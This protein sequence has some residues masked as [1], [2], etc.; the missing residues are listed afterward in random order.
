MKK[1]F[2]LFVVLMIALSLLCTSYAKTFSDV[3]NTKYA[4]AV[5]M[6]SGLGIVDGYSDGTFKPNNDITRA[7]VCKLIVVMLAKG[8]NADSLKGSTAFSD[9]GSN[10]WASGYIN[11]ASSQGIIKGYPDGSFKPGDPVTYA[12]AATM[13]LRSLNYTKELE[14]EKYPLGYMTKAKEAGILEGVTANSSSDKSIRGNIANMVLNTLLSNTRK[15]V[16]TT[17]KGEVTY[18]DSTPLIE[19]SFPDYKLFN[20]GKVIDVDFGER[21]ITVKDDNHRVACEVDE[22]TKLEE[23]YGRLVKLLY[24]SKEQKIVTL[25]IV[26]DYK[27]VEVNVDEIDDDDEILYDEDD[28][29]YDIPDD[30]LMV[31]VY[32]YDEVDTAYILYD[33]KKI[34]AIVLM[35]TP[36]IYAGIVT[37]SD[38]T[39][40]KK[41]GFEIIDVDGK[42]KEYA[43]AN[44]SQ[45]ISDDEFLLY[46]LSSSN[47]AVIHDAISR[48][49]AYN[50][51][52][53]TS[54]SIKLQKKTA[55]SLTSEVEYYVYL[56]DT[57]NNL[58]EG[59]LKDIDDEFDTAYIAKYSDVYYIVVF[60]DSV[61]DDDIVSKLS[62]SDAKDLLDDAIRAA[63]KYLKKETSYSVET[64]EELREAVNDGTKVLNSSS[65]AAKLELAAKKITE[66][67]E[68]LEAAKSSDK[69]LRSDYEDLQ[70]LIE[71]AE[72]KKANEFTEA[73][74]KDLQSELKLAKA[75]KLSST[76]LSKISDRYDALKKAINMLVTNTANNEIQSA[77]KT[78]QSLL[79]KG[80][81]AVSN[82]SSYTD[83]SYSKFISVYNT[84]KD[85]D[86][87]SASLA[88]IKT[89]SSNLEAALDQLE[90]KLL[91]DYTKKRATLDKDYKDATSKDKSQYTT[92]SYNT[93][94]TTLEALKKTYNGLVKPENINE[95]SNDS[96]T[97]EIGKMEDLDNKIKAAV[98]KLVTITDSIYRTNLKNAI[99]KG[100]TYT[101][102]TW[103]GS[104][105]FEEFTKV[106][107]NAEKIANNSNS[108][109][110]Q[111]KE[112][113]MEL[114]GYFT[115]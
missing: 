8:E 12:E 104:I 49:E 58:E 42:E 35:G 57:K 62:V 99:A 82:K 78:L 81:N 96:I 18:G 14:K 111:V 73:S 113:Y 61:D 91:A 44:S 60:E 24:N 94:S 92:E 108:T 17:S 105:S 25:E 50:I 63:K 107:A 86:T 106:L 103:K 47:N 67:Q 69:Q 33:G 75:V 31:D 56:I 11:Y 114:M 71:E 70:K 32:N 23:L 22:K 76:T 89:Q 110:D 40:N 77:L 38:V 68:N 54:N 79:N 55:V 93:F 53:V 115:I 85:F 4:E 15:I 5:D 84:A 43:K 109:E 39:V 95:L 66:A 30:T 19:Q 51:E 45:K 52:E 41:A 112:T 10:H 36:K 98:A 7:E 72:A 64:F 34:I 83:A 27:V 59:K 102:A 13:L 28:E 26:D 20:E 6:L 101:K 1:S 80:A 16:S 21:E 65:S 37:D 100:K 74:Y 88:E 97:S 29:E 90:S 9:V 48:K 3:K 46:S 2:I 87:S